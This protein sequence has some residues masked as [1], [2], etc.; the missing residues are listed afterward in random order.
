[1]TRPVVWLTTSPRVAPGLLSRDAWRVLFSAEEH[2]AVGAGPGHPQRA[3]LAEVGIPVAEPGGAYD[4]G[5]AARVTWALESLRSTGGPVVWLADPVDGDPALAEA[6]AGHDVGRAP[7]AGSYDLPGA[8]VIDL[9]AVLDRLRSP[10][11]CPWD[12]AQTHASLLAFLLEETYEV[13]EAVETDDRSAMREELG[14]LLLQVVFHARLAEEDLGD[15]WGIDQVAEAIA[16]KL[17]RRHPHVFAPGAEPASPGRPGV[18]GP[19]DLP[20]W[21]E[22]GWDARKRAEKQRGSVLDG[23]PLAQPGLALAAAVAGRA[24]RAGVMAT[25]TGD[26]EDSRGDVGDRLLALAAAA[27]AQGIDPEGAL[28]AAVRRYADQVRQAERESAPAP[29]GEPRTPGGRR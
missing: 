18:A 4:L 24:R 5:Q 11:G 8:Q 21:S 7:L 22:E 25:P 12:A 20:A 19:L 16:A 9:V 29:Q 27:Q 14:D 15:P 6:L 3:G 13:I 28:R 2:G 26:Q 17:V 1:M 23:V 10:G